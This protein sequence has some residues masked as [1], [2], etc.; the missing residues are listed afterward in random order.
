[1]ISKELLSEVLGFECWN[2]KT[3]KD[4]ALYVPN[5]SLGFEYKDHIAGL[6]NIHEL[7][8]KCKEWA[9][10]KDY[11]ITSGNR[12]DGTL[13]YDVLCVHKDT[14]IE[15]WDDFFSD[16]FDTEPEAIFKACEWILEQKAKS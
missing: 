1:M 16:M 2:I 6:V 4:G 5:N 15:E 7:A 14:D 10:G 13:R 9:R 3:A 8:H 12:N 11:S